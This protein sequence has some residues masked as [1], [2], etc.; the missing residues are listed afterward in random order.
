MFD[1]SMVCIFPQFDEVLEDCKCVLFSC[2]DNSTTACVL[3]VI[4]FAHYSVSSS[5]NRRAVHVK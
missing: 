5:P 4:I 3:D 1:L 2:K